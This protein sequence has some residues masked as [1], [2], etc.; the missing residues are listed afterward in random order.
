MTR[1]ASGTSRITTAPAATATAAIRNEI[2]ALNKNIP[3]PKIE[4]M[5][6]MLSEV[7]AEPRLQTMLLALFGLVALLLAAVGIYSVMAYSVTQRTHEIGIRMA[8]G[9]QVRDVLR[10]VI[11]QGLRLVLLG[12][13]LG[14][15]GA[16]VMTRL[17]RSLL[18]GVTATDPV[19]FVAVALLLMTVALL[20]CYLPARRATKVEPM[21][22]LRCE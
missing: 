9:A 22:A 13:A 5:D 16:F 10:L 8:L 18:F 17:M 14:L 20:A 11:G 7:V 1:A 6:A 2:K 12:V 4:T 19:T 3:A 15:S 21:M